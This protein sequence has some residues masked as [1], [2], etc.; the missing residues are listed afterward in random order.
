MIQVRPSDMNLIYKL[1]CRKDFKTFYPFGNPN[2]SYRVN[3][4]TLWKHLPLNQ[5]TLI[6]IWGRLHY[7]SSHAPTTIKNRWK[8]ASSRFDKHHFGCIRRQS[9]RFHNKYTAGAWL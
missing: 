6:C 1:K 7:L 5:R 8:K 2:F 3:N 9:A 4:K